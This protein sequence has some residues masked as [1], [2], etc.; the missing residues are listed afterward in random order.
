MGINLYSASSQSNYTEVLLVWQRLGELQQLIPSIEA[1][2]GVGSR[3][4]HELTSFSRQDRF[5]MRLMFLDSTK[6]IRR[7]WIEFRFPCLLEVF[8]HL[9]VEF[10]NFS[11]NVVICKW[12]FNITIILINTY[13]WHRGSKPVTCWFLVFIQPYSTK[14]HPS[15]F[16]SMMH[17]AYFPPI[18]TKNINFPLFSPKMYF[19]LFSFNLRSY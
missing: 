19:L 9:F 8:S 2:G 5:Q 18:F 17:I 12:L 13:L 4:R 6:K 3:R 14:G 10:T 16:K 1:D 11:N 7:H 15:P